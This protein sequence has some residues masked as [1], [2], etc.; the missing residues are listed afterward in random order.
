M[1]ATAYENMKRCTAVLG[2]TK[3][4]QDKSVSANV[5]AVCD[6][7]NDVIVE[8]FGGLIKD[9]E[10]TFQ[11]NM[12]ALMK[13]ACLMPTRWV[14][15][16]AIIVYPGNRE[17]AGLIPVDA[18][19]LLRI[20]KIKGFSWQK[21]A[22]AQAAEI[23]PNVRYDWINFNV[24]LAAGSKGLLPPVKAERAQVATT[25]G[26]HSC[27][28]LRIMEFAAKG[29]HKDLCVDGTVSKTRC[30]EAQKSLAE[31]CEKG[32]KLDVICYQLVDACPHLMQVM[33]RTGNAD[34]DTARVQTALQSCWR[35]LNLSKLY[36]EDLQAT[37]RAACQGKPAEY[38]SVAKNFLEFTDKQAGGPDGPVLVELE[39]FEKTLEFKRKLDDQTFGSL[40]QVNIPGCRRI[41]P[42]MV[43]AMLASPSNYEHLGYSTLITRTDITSLLPGSKNKIHAKE[44]NILMDD[45][46]EFLTGYAKLTELEFTV[47]AGDV[48]IACIMHLFKKKSET[49][50]THNH[51][52]EIAKEGYD[53]ANK[54]MADKGLG[55]LPKWRYLE[56]KEIS[57]K[58]APSAPPRMQVFS[59]ESGRVL[60]NE[61]QRVGFEVGACIA[62]KG[63]DKG[64]AQAYEIVDIAEDDVGIKQIVPADGQEPQ[65][66]KK[67]GSK[68]CRF[69]GEAHRTAG[70]V[71]IALGG[72]DCGAILIYPKT[73]L[74]KK[75][76]T[77]NIF[78]QNN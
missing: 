14:P 24:K 43:K 53:A 19:D 50:P 1:Q 68:D 16:D 73:Y 38:E 69:E 35:M 34:H 76:E 49:R 57:K 8:W 17:G 67:K 11:E 22:G 15:L 65:A 71:E 23:P 33:S 9:G 77:K 46:R 41:V 32:M 44:C 72:G 64:I 63:D 66:K 54:I 36:P 61:L 2:A 58:P 7:I 48:D 40:A 30:V 27:A 3:E 25:R 4:A 74:L 52:T 51:L 60:D 26:S 47:L 55:P 12:C 59:L 20:F 78:L 45:F 31:P 62:R 42:A 37:L 56:S 75:Q 29:I 6:I 13:A 21:A 28:A 10:E 18:H 5:A 70:R 39:Q